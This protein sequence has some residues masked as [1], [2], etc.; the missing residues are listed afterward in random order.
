MSAGP[1]ASTLLLDQSNWDLALEA[2]A[3]IAVAQTPYATAQD[4]SSAIRTFL[5]ECFYDDSLGVQ[6]FGAILG[7]NP[8]LSF[9]TAQM[10]AAALTVPGVVS[11]TCTIQ[12]VAGRAITGQ[13]LFTDVNHVTQTLAIT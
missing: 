1:T 5:G 8:P 10:E 2:N 6:Y 4:V 7:K 11:A 13:V 9:V 12:A 3:N